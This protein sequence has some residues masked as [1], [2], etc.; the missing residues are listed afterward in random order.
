MADAQS[1]S[2]LARCHLYGLVKNMRRAVADR[3]C[4]NI[5]SDTISSVKAGGG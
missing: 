4:S 2:D 3:L 5:C 1:K